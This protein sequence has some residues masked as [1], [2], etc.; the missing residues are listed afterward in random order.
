[1]MEKFQ[2]LSNSKE[3]GAMIW[4]EIKEITGIVVSSVV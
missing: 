4:Q 3:L 2:K 1:M